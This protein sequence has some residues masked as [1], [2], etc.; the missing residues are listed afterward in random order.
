M[1]IVIEYPPALGGTQQEQLRQVYAYLVQMSDALNSG[2][3]NL[4]A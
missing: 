2:M 1:S 4:S 3:N